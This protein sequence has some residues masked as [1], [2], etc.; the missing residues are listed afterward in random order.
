MF[1]GDVERICYVWMQC[2]VIIVGCQVDVICFQ[3]IFNCIISS[4]DCCVDIVLLGCL[5]FVYVCMYQCMSCIQVDEGIFCYFEGEVC[6]WQNFGV[7]VVVG[8]G[9]KFDIINVDSVVG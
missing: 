5:Y 1:E 3:I 2:W 8:V 6:V 9:F 4:I 7:F